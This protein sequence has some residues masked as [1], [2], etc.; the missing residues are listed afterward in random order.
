MPSLYCIKFGLAIA[1]LIMVG[2]VALFSL[3][4]ALSSL[5]IQ[6]HKEK[7]GDQNV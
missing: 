5:G 4:S 3:I 6:H 7:V 2:I 1:G